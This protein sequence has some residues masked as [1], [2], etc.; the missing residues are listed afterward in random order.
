[1]NLEGKLDAE[2]FNRIKKTKKNETIAL[3]SAE[4]GRAN[5]EL[6][7]IDRVIIRLFRSNGNF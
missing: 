5:C 3:S 7:R 6:I 2:F 1:M 4:A